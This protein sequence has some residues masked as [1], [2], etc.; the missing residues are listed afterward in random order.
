MANISTKFKL[1]ALDTDFHEIVV[2]RDNLSLEEAER[3]KSNFSN[4]VAI[5]P[6]D[7]AEHRNTMEE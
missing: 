3:I 5:E 7:K 6:M 1:V 4:G 2:I